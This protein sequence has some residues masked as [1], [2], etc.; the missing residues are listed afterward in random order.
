M[1]LNK[2]KFAKVCDFYDPDKKSVCNIRHDKTY[3]GKYRILND[4]LNGYKK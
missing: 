4:E 2:C 3:C 1:C